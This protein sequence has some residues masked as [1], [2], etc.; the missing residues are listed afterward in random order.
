MIVFAVAFGLSGIACGAAFLASY[1]ADNG[2]PFALPTLT[3]TP[4]PALAAPVAAQPLAPVWCETARR[5]RHPVTR[6]FVKAPR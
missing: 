1:A 3:R 6:A 4:A 2:L 5:W